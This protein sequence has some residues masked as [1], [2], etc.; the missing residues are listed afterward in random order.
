[1]PSMPPEEKKEKRK[2]LDPL[3]GQFVVIGF[4]EVKRVTVEIIQSLK[5]LPASHVVNRLN[6]TAETE[7]R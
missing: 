4:T 1:M 3:P 7:V 2:K 6:K 5:S